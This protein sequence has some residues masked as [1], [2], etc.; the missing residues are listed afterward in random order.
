MPY[1]PFRFSLAERQPRHSQSRLS[2]Q[3]T[4]ILEC[5]V[6]LPLPPTP[7]N[8]LL[9]PR[10]SLFLRNTLSRITLGLAAKIHSFRPHS[11]R[12]LRSLGKCARRILEV[13]SSKSAILDGGIFDKRKTKGIGRIWF[14]AISALSFF[15]SRKTTPA[16]AIE[17]IIPI[18]FYLECSVTLP[19]PLYRE[20]DC[21]SRGF[22]SFCG[23]V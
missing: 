5:S 23:A 18:Y 10:F 1:L 22:L 11:L 7:R 4:F 3:Y 2:F 17:I 9:E 20:I 14:Y 21:L 8:R 16:F 19:P 6:T 13:R 15:A 12:A